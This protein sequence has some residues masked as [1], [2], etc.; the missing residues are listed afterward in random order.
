MT[1]EIEK[2]LFGTSLHLFSCTDPNDIVGHGESQPTVAGV[3]DIGVFSALAL[4]MKEKE[5]VGFIG[6]KEAA[7]L[8]SFRRH[9][10][11]AIQVSDHAIPYSLFL[12]PGR[13]G[14]YV[15]WDQHRAT[16]RQDNETEFT[17]YLEFISSHW[18]DLV[19][20]HLHQ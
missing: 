17:Y 8:E 10:D 15:F 3:R 20:Q 7:S 16:S 13:T 2:E 19:P 12:S 14:Y 18:V 11:R 6:F 4:P 9:H 1:I 5:L